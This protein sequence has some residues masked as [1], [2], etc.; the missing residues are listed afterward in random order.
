MALGKWE[1]SALLLCSDHALSPAA[2]WRGT[3]A[4]TVLHKPGQEKAWEGVW[5]PAWDTVGQGTLACWAPL[6]LQA[7]WVHLP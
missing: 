4:G 5:P 6:A 2:F 3:L 1:L 7:A